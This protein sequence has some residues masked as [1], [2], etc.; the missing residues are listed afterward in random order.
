MGRDIDGMDFSETGIA[1]DAHRCG[2]SSRQRPAGERL[3][4]GMETPIDG[5]YFRGEKITNVTHWMPLPAPPT[6]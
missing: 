3:L 4:L 6:T 5:W 2:H 1:E